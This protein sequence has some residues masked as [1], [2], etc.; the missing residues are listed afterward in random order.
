MLRNDLYKP[1]FASEKDWG[2]EIIDGQFSGVIVQIERVE[3]VET[4]DGNLEAEYHIVS[5]PEIISDNDIKSDL[6]EAIFQNIIVDIIKEAVEEHEQ[7]RNNNT[8][9]SSS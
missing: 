8:E 1:W 6:F 7:N 4:E 2:F 5:K 9:K 3:F